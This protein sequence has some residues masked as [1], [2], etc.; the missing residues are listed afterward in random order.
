MGAVG[1][2][3]VKIPTETPRPRDPNRHRAPIAHVLI[4]PLG[5]AS[6]LLLTNRFQ[7]HGRGVWRGIGTAGGN[8]E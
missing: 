8:R 3:L 7:G 2:P 6:V 1:L 5:A 4:F